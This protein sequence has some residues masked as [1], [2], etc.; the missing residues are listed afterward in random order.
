MR[1]YVFLQ[2][3]CRET[4]Q[5]GQEHHN[6]IRCTEQTPLRRQRQRQ[7]DEL[8]TADN[9]EATAVAAA[10]DIGMSFEGENDL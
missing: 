1:A 5:Q 9:K 6:R 7:I 10:L 8:T 4:V 3:Q 2:V